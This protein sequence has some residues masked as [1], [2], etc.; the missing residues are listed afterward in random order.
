MGANLS[1]VVMDK[2]ANSTDVI[3][4]LFG[5]RERLAHEPRAPLPQRIVEALDV[6]SFARFLT[7]CLMTF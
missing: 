7:N 2:I 3:G 5:K 1:I 6:S 4:K